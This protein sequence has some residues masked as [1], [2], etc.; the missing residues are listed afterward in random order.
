[1]RRYFRFLVAGLASEVLEA[2]LRNYG[3][4]YRA[5]LEGRA[6]QRELALRALRKVATDE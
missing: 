2:R 4:N 1:M 3:P 6:A 5:S